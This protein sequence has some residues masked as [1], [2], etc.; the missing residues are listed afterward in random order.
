MSKE[1]NEC[2]CNNQKDQENQ[3]CNCEDHHQSCDHEHNHGHEHDHHDCDHD[4]EHGE[5][6]K[7]Y[8]TL[9]DGGKL[10]CDVVDIFEIGEKSYIALL[11]VNS[12]TVILYGFTENDQGPQLRNIEDDDEYKN[13][14]KAFMERQEE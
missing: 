10:E 7:I 11:P 1:S 4:H 8:L 5:P 2:D 9:M 3:N 12:E 14:S 6:R 13:A